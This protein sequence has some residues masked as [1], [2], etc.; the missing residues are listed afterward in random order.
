M[1]VM[2]TEETFDQ[3]EGFVLFLCRHQLVQREIRKWRLFLHVPASSSNQQALPQVYVCVSRRS[4][5]GLR[6]LAVQTRQVSG[7]LGVNEVM[8]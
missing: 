7:A 4:G 2:V 3:A 6:R 8:C 5:A 1:V